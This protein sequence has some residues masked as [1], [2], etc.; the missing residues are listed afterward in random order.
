M[1]GYYA[2]SSHEIQLIFSFCLMSLISPKFK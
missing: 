1:S 2:I